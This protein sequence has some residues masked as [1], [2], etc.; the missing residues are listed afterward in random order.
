[1][2]SDFTRIESRHPSLKDGLHH[3]IMSGFGK[4]FCIVFPAEEELAC[5]GSKVPT[6]YIQCNYCTT[7]NR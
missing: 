5:S 4:N 6:D 7:A 1:M 2:A 3:M